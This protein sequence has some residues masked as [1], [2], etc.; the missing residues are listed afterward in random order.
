MSQRS[1]IVIGAGAAGLAAARR[2]HDGGADVLVLEAR[3][4]VGGRAWTSYD[5]ASHPVELGAEFIHGENVAT[6]EYVRRFGLTT[7]DQF[8]LMNV[9]AF[10][11]ER[12]LD[13]VEFLQ[14]PNTTLTWRMHDMAERWMADG[15]EDTDVL[16]AGRATPGWL[17]GELTPTQETFWNNQ[18]AGLHAGDLDQMGCAGLLESTYTGDGVRIQYRLNEGY[19]AL[20][21]RLAEGLDVRL[22]TAVTRI[23]WGSAGVSVTTASG[24][25]FGAGFCI[26]TLPLSLLQRGAITFDAALPTETQRAIGALGAGDIAKVLLRFQEPFWPDDMTYLLTVRD[27][28]MYWRPGRVRVDEAPVLTAFIG[29]RAVQ[30]MAALGDEGAVAASVGHLEEIFGGVARSAFVDGR[31]VNWPADPWAGMGYS[32]APPGATGMRDVLAE[33]IG[34]AL[35]LAGEATNAIRPA[36]VHGAIESGWRAVALYEASQARA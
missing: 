26:V 17:H 6:W 31:L 13:Q 19:S 11:G 24:E 33:P 22:S 4:R 32:Y 9:R 34:D 15:R 8:P 36:T 18:V 14:A 3:D 16:T 21:Q 23:N 7:N 1:V 5:F 27:S 12:L 29:G 20:M 30:R 10:D 25:T 28:Q 2:L 35:A